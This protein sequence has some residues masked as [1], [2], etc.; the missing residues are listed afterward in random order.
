[1]LYVWIGQADFNKL[2]Y[3]KEFFY[4]LYWQKSYIVLVNTIYFVR[5]CLEVIKTLL[6]SKFDLLCD[7]F[8]SF[9]LVSTRVILSLTLKE[10]GI[11]IWLVCCRP[12]FCYCRPRFRSKRVP[13]LLISFARH[14]SYCCSRLENEVYILGLFLFVLAHAF[15]VH[16][17]SWIV[18]FFRPTQV[19]LSLTLRER[20]IHIRLVLVLV[21]S[22]CCRPRF[23]VHLFIVVIQVYPPIL[24]IF[25]VKSRMK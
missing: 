11:H 18:N 20:G 2:C 1:M 17:G 16:A 13:G 10:R 15:A 4:F 24:Q 5:W 25:N 12:C 22:C 6:L 21:C 9:S 23:A 14:G 8:N 7:F 3:I 19:I